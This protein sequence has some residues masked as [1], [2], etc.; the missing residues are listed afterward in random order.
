MKKDDISTLYTPDFIQEIKQI[1]TNARQ[2]AYVAINSA[3]VEAYWLMG[4]RIVEQEQ[5]GKGRADYGSRYWNRSRKNLPQNLA[6]VSLLG[7][8]II[9]ANFIRLF[10]KY[11]LHRGEFWHGHTTSV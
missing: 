5:E 9:I 6:K 3:M 10:L 1:V 2:K 11:S 7:R 4:K 8:Y